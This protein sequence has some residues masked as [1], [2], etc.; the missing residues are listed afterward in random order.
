MERDAKIEKHLGF[1]NYFREFI[2]LYSK[3]TPPLDRLG[4]KPLRLFGQKSMLA[5]IQQYGIR[6]CLSLEWTLNHL[7]IVLVCLANNS[8]YCLQCLKL[9]AVTLSKSWIRLEG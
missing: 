9:A 6:I 4:K 1:F 3:L 2:P 7:V 5:F 8:L